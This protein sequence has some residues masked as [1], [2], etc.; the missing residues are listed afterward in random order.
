MNSVLIAPGSA[1]ITILTG[2][3]CID[4]GTLAVANGALAMPSGAS[5]TIPTDMLM[6]QLILHVMR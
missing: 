2:S 3:N 6:V 1:S 4:S 5:M